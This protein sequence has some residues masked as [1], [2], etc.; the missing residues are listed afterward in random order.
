MLP[1]IMN[2]MAAAEMIA[3]VGLDHFSQPLIL[4]CCLPIHLRR[5]RLQWQSI[6]GLGC[7]SELGI[8]GLN[9]GLSRSHWRKFAV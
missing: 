4:R 3:F 8:P 2:L 5:P 7:A 6:A 1:H 9:P